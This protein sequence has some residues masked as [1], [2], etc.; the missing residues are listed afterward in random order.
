MVSD[1]LTDGDLLSLW[2][3]LLISTPVDGKA[4]RSWPGTSSPEMTTSAQT[5][6]P[7]GMAKGT[8]ILT[9]PRALASK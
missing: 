1:N 9:E 7:S 6:S 8:G 2:K 4:V 5:G 3:L